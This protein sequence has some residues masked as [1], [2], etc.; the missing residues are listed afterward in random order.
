MKIVLIN[1]RSRRPEEIQQKCF[2][3]VNLL[4]LASSL[5]RHH[6]DVAIVDANAYG[7]SDAAD[8]EHVIAAHG[9]GRVQPSSESSGTLCT[10]HRYDQVRG[11]WRL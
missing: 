6:Y 8:R 1:P 9:V 2:A 7:L 5:L 10:G 4:Y 3:P 11:L